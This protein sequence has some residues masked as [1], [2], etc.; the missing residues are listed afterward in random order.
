LATICPRIHYE[1]PPAPTIKATHY[2]EFERFFAFE[3]SCVGRRSLA[4]TVPV[5]CQL[6]GDVRFKHDESAL[7][8]S[9]MEAGQ[10]QRRKDAVGRKLLVL[11]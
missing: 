1:Q 7:K 9:S 6:M 8:N 2:Q 10:V 5:V 3:N 11:N 4:S